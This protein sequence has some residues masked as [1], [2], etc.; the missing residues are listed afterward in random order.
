[1]SHSYNKRGRALC[2]HTLNVAFIPS[3]VNATYIYQLLVTFTT[4][5]IMSYVCLLFCFC[6]VFCFL[7]VVVF[8]YWFV[9]FVSVC[10]LLWGFNI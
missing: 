7:F 2:D 3:F 4:T 10:L 9:L 6:C 5:D 1:M 8:L